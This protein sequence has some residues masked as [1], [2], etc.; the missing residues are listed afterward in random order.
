MRRLLMIGVLVGAIAVLVVRHPPTM[1]ALRAHNPAGRYGRKLAADL[2]RSK[3]GRA[4]SG[5]KR[6]PVVYRIR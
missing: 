1:D 2:Q 3:L 5:T 4:F 6:A